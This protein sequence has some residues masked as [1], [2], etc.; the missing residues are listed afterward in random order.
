[1]RVFTHPLI[2]GI[3]A[4]VV[5]A[6]CYLP[7]GPATSD[8]TRYLAQEVFENAAALPLK[9]WFGLEQEYVI[10]NSSTGKPLAWPANSQCVPLPQGP[11]YCGTNTT[12]A[13]EREIAN[14]HLALGLKMGL[15]LSGNNAE[16]MPSQWEYQVGPCEGLESGDHT[17][18]ARWLM[19]RICEQVGNTDA[20]FASKV[21]T[22][23]DWNGSGLHTNFSTKPM[24]EEGGY[25]II[26]DTMKRLEEEP[27]RELTFYGLDNHLRLSGHHETSRPEVFNF[28][29]GGR[30]TSVRIPNAVK[31]EQKGYFEDR[32]PAG[33]ADPYLITARLFATSCAIP[34]PKLDQYRHVLHGK[35]HKWLDE[36]K[37]K[38]AHHAKAA[39]APAA[40]AH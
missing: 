2:Q 25:K 21:V 36:L 9:P 8:N 7:T 33:S 29:V 11:Y 27:L 3:A 17:V 26:L 22:D 35:M 4:F 19:L 20:S 38:Q 40:A 28:S 39:A 31:E 34:S 13:V 15:K 12:L 37:A 23:G 30:A 5:L 16:V 18:M 6:D 14:K 32:R 1:V 10:M 24:R